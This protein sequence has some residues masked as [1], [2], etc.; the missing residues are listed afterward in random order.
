M[1][2][3]SN[4]SMILQTEFFQQSEI[5]DFLKQMVFLRSF[6]SVFTGTV[7]TLAVPLFRICMISAQG[8]S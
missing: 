5:P 4:F 8:S 1:P 3:S 7:N 2:C 6:N